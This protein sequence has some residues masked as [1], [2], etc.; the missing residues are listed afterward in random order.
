VHLRSKLRHLRYLSFNDLEL[1]LSLLKLKTYHADLLL[2]GA[3]GLFTLLESVL[4]NV[5]LFVVDAELVVSVDELNTHIVTGL[6][7]HLVFVDKIIH[8]L[9]KGVND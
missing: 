2:L 5:A 3:N 6:T 8:L 7:S 1:S 9:L 4:L